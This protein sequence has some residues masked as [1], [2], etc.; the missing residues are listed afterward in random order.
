MRRLRACLFGLMFLTLPAVASAESDWWDVIEGL[1]GPGPFKGVTFG[2][3]IFCVKENEGGRSHSLTSC[4]SDVDDKIRALVNAEVGF[5]TSGDR[6][7]F[8]DTPNDRAT[9]HLWRLH[10]TYYLRISPLLDIGAGGG[11]L[12]FTGDGFEHQSH[13]VVT[14]VE[15]V[16]VPLGFIRSSPHATKWGR[17]LRLH[18][19][20]SWVFG[21]IKAA[22]FGSP[23]TYLRT[24]EF[25]RKFGFGVD[26]GSLIAH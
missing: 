1:S 20:E 19:S 15:I 18:F 21:D 2:Q 11:V 24:G 3:R 6:P 16:F 7:R 5:Y 12:I 9:V 13:P 22:D 23:S 26:I 4:M 25:N 14:P 17:L 10:S 8:S